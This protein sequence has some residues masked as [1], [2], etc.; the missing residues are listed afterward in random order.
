[1]HSTL[2]LVQI[3]IPDIFLPKNIQTSLIFLC[4]QI[5]QTE[6]E[7]FI[8]LDTN[9]FHMGRPVL[10]VYRK[11][12]FFIVH[13]P[14]L[15]ILRMIIHYHRVNDHMKHGRFS[16]TGST[17]DQSVGI[18]GTAEFYARHPPSPVDCKRNFYFAL[19]IAVFQFH[20]RSILSI[21]IIFREAGSKTVV[22]LLSGLPGF[23]YF[24]NVVVVIPVF[25]Q[26]LYYIGFLSSCRYHLRHIVSILYQGRKLCHPQFI[27]ITVQLFLHL[28]LI[29][30]ENHKNSAPGTIYQQFSDQCLF[31]ISVNT[32]QNYDLVRDLLLV[33]PVVLFKSGL[34]LQKICHLSH[35]FFQAEQFLVDSIRISAHMKHPETIRR[36]LWNDQIRISLLY[37]LKL[38]HLPQS[39]AVVHPVQI[40]YLIAV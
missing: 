15:Y 26:Q 1:M 14:N 29:L 7:F 2:F 6:R 12:Y 30:Q 28:R 23:Q 32:I 39:T 20:C 9:K 24:C 3:N 33:F 22:E 18:I 8:S 21:D 19:Q 4:D 35:I 37:I 11:F 16:G 13:Q 34:S 5:Q 25:F 36:Q 31:C 40:I 38:Q 10:Y 27:I 17:G